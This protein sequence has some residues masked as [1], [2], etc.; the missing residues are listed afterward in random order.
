M[1]LRTA[2]VAAGFVLL[3]LSLAAQTSPN[4]PA[5]AQVPPLIQFSNVATDEGGNTLSGEVSITFSLYNN[6]Q[7]GEPLWTETQ[8]NIPLDPTG[9]YS[10]ELG[11]TKPNGVP[12]NMFT[13]GEARWLGVRIAEQGEHPRVL[14]LSVPYALKAGDAATIGGL[15]PSAFVLASPG[16]ESA[17]A[18]FAAETPTSADAP[19]AGG[20]TGSGT[21]DFI[22][23]WTSASNLA[24]SALFQSGTGATAKI[25]VGTSTPTTTLDVQGSE[26]VSGVLLLPASGTATASKGASSQPLALTASAFNSAS[27]TAVAQNFR[28]Q[29]QP[30]GNNTSNPTGSLYLLYSSGSNAGTETGLQISA[31]GLFTFAPGQTFPG[32]GSITGITTAT[33]SGLSGGGTGGTLN[34]ALQAC[35]PNQVLEFVGGA[36]TCVTAGTGTVT[37]ITAGS[38]LNGGTIT[39]SGTLSVNGA[40]VPLLAAANTFTANQTVSGTLTATSFSGSGAGVTGVNASQLGGLASSA[41]AQLSTA[42]TFA[43]S[44]NMVSDTRVDYNNLNQG[45]YTPAIRFGSGKTG[46]AISS[47]RA[48]VVNVNGIDLYTDFTP[49]LSVTNGGSVGI[50][51]QA[52]VYTLDVQGTGSFSSGVTGISTSSSVPAGIFGGFSAALNSGLAGSDGVDGYGGLADALSSGRGGNGV[53]GY[54]GYGGNYG[55]AGNGVVGFGAGSSLQTPA[56]GGVIGTGGAGYTCG[57]CDAVDDG[58]GGAFTGGNESFGGDGIDAYTGSGYAG[59]FSGDVYISGTL[60]GGG[61]V[62]KMDHP[63]DPADKYFIHA[64]VESSEMKNLYDGNV[65]TDSEGHATVQLPEWFELLNTDFRYQLTVIGQFAQAIVGRKIENNRFEIR[66]SAPNVEVSWQV[67]GVRQDAY[68]KAHPLV[69]E[70]EKEARLRGFYIHPEL[71]GAPPE[72]QIEWARH[73]Q[74]MKEIKEMQAKQRMRTGAAARPAPAQTK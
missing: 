35:G 23:L 42:D 20:V 49:R 67:T 10:V 59:S 34:L 62:V 52:P 22:P 48:G 44:V 60:Y 2:C 71:Y 15:P 18:T 8:N 6:Q 4:S 33:G 65:T 61:A 29:A 5:S 24:S 68:A 11:I 43:G 47:D 41:F 63:L 70:E 38:G 17:S 36:W 1:K 58:P 21:A 51:T 55:T 54:G 56:G 13:T 27:G 45:S 57:N 40:V 72:K 32:T 30:V 69:V 53:T 16:T 46:E 39:S 50:G 19:P 25:G 26:T 64:S 31:K 9:H 3:G 66:T 74:L 7:G 14:L 73:P 37:S 12:T 28:W